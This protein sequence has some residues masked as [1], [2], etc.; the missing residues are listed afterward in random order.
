MTAAHAIQIDRVGP[1][2][3]M[4]L[5]EVALAEPRAGEVVLRQTAVGLNFIDVYQ[6]S[7]AYPIDLPFTPGNEA[8]GVVEALGPGVGGLAI[9]D[10]V[11]YAAPGG[12][13]YADRRVIA[14]KHLVRLPASIDDRVAAAVML[15]GLTAQIL[16]HRVFKVQPGQTILVHAAAGA[17]GLILCQWAAAL[18][19]TVIGTVGSAEK[20]NLALA[21]GCSHAINY[22][23]E[24]FLAR[25]K[26]I[27]GGAG[28]EV[29]YDSVGKDVFPASL[30][31]LKPFGLWALFGQSSGPP[32]PL[33]MQ[34]LNRKGCL[35]ATRPTVF[36]YVAR[37]RDL[38]AAAASLF[39]A[40]AKGI[41]RVAI[42][43]DFRLANVA[44]AHRLLESRSTTGATVLIP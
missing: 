18:G 26:E 30:D 40:I 2:E 8:A 27:T 7:G 34:I 39:E 42:N 25:V 11:G 13:G 41:L 9:G 33:D 1:P 24:D 4:E 14:A 29:V 32:P 23:T 44:E 38:E 12:G 15:K 16:L 17:V 3:V 43:Q 21:N 6:R 36:T 20:A 28:V 22:R 10:R 31:C 5:R 35:F 19:A 37:R